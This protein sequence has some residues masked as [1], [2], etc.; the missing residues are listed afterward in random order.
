MQKAYFLIVKSRDYYKYGDISF[1]SRFRIGAGLF[2]VHSL[3][4][5]PISIIPCSSPSFLM[6]THLTFVQL[7]LDVSHRVSTA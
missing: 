6:P 5:L 3:F 7:L 4:R 2:C 1:F